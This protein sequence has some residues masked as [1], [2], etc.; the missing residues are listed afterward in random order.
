M[1]RTLSLSA[2][3]I[4][5]IAV[6]GATTA[7]AFAQAPSYRAVPSVAIAQADTVV[8]GETLWRCA[9]GGCTAT[10]ATS[11]PAIVCAQAARKIGRLDSFTVGGEALDADTL[12]KCNAKAKDGGTALAAK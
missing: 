2:A 1:V 11:R 8:A 3:L 10:K 5:S 7:P 6:L 4:T 9:P 12:A